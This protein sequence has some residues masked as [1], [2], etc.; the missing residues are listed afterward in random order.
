M[1]S[2][3]AENSQRVWFVTGASSGFGRAVSRTVLQRGERLVATG[4]DHDA[5]EALVAPFPERA[6]ALRLDV[7]DAGSVRK[8]VSEAIARFGRIDVVF[9]NAGYGHIGA[10]EE[11][12]DEEL[13]RQL[14]VNLLGV[15]HVTRAVLPHLRKQRSGHLVQMSSLNG[16]EGLPGAAYYTASKFAI[17]GFSE[18]L[19]AEVAHLG[20]K[21]TIVEPAPFRTRFLDDRSARWARPIPD[22]AESV[23]KSREMLR[24]LNGKQPGDPERA[25]RAIVQIADAVRPPLRLA[26]G[27]MAIDHI[28]TGLNAELAELDA[29]AELGAAADFPREGQAGRSS[30]ED[31]VRRAYAAFNDREIEAAVALMAP[32]VDWPNA[33]DGSFVHGRDQV[34]K[35]WSEQF[36]QVVPRIEITGLTETPDGHVEARVHQLVHDRNGKKLSDDQLVHVFTIDHDPR[37]RAGSRGWRSARELDPECGSP[38]QRRR[39]TPGARK[40]EIPGESSFSRDIKLLS[41][42]SGGR[43]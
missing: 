37:A 14:D 2:N 40:L 23:G 28:R 3:T 19:A 7:A 6:L 30:H 34:R 43:I 32:D 41:V 26:V 29:W 18:S 33:S 38:K 5:L 25:A 4:R 9:N 36:R 35:H 15:I 42:S 21:V 8:T 22:Y 31:L 17:E 13:R 27:R 20:I 12:N 10:V 1:Q 24:Q 11:L 16:V 39:G